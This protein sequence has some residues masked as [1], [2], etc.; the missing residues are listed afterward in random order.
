MKKNKRKFVMSIVFAI[1][2]S[3]SMLTPISA[4]ENDDIIEF[5]E[6]NLGE[7]IRI[8][9]GDAEYFKDFD[10]Q[11]RR[12]SELRTPDDIIGNIENDYQLFSTK[13]DRLID[14][15]TILTAKIELRLFYITSEDNN[16]GYIMEANGYTTLTGITVGQAYRENFCNTEIRGKDVYVESVGEAVIS[17]LIDGFIE[18]S[19]SPVKLSGTAWVIR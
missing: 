6:V 10:G 7:T 19:R 17:L 11:I 16:R 9:I 14:S 13:S 18:V 5:P 4:K 8:P 2:M 1:A 12:I 3:M 15:T